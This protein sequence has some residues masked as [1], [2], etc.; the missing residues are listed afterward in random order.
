MGCAT[1]YAT[2]AEYNNTFCV[3]LDLADPDV[4]TEIETALKSAAGQISVS[5]AAVGACNCTFSAGVLAYL[6]NLN[7]VLA[8]INKSCPCM[9]T[10]DADERR[11]LREWANDQLK[12]IRTGEIPI[13]E[14]DTG[15]LYPA[16][17][18]A[19]NNLTQWSPEE[20]IYNRR[21]RNS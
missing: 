17:G 6:S 7:I 8:A 15:S 14:G 12:L 19:E 13:C 18:W 9:P 1:M 20:I 4:V 16:F 5:I 3:D 2:A 21:L 10:I 11:D